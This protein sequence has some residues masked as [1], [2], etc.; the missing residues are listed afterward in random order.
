MDLGT[1]R[2]GSIDHPVPGV[3]MRGERLRG[4]RKKTVDGPLDWIWAEEIRSH[5]FRSVVVDPKWC[6]SDWVRA[7]PFG[8][9]KS[10]H[11]SLI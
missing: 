10:D 1:D 2:L 6:G 5:Q 11:R 7:Y 8:P 4:V 9:L 3:G